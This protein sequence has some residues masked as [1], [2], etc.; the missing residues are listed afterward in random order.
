[1]IE[2][3]YEPDHQVYVT[4]RIPSENT[5]PEVADYFLQ[6]LQGCGYKLDRDDLAAYYGDPNA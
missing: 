4:V 1:M 3:K 5:W 2:F 6:F